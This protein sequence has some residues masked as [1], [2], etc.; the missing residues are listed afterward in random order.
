MTP[1]ALEYVRERLTPELAKAVAG[2][3]P[4]EMVG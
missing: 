4:E 2:E 1:L 3:A